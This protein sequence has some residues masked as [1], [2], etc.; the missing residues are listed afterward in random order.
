MA[1][2]QVYDKLAEVV[3]NRVQAFELLA[4]ARH[5]ATE[6]RTT[7][8]RRGSDKGR[9]EQEAPL[10]VNVLVT[11]S[12]PRKLFGQV[13][14]EYSIAND[15]YVPYLVR[16]RPLPVVSHIARITYDVRLFRRQRGHWRTRRHLVP[17]C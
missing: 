11:Q 8:D 1:Q 4:M 9:P 15:R 5:R 2:Y 10:L 14:V 6:Y 3:G 16:K 12:V 7:V 17:V 13:L